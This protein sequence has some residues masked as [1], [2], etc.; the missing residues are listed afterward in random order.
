[1]SA[2]GDVGERAPPAKA[3][4][5]RAYITIE[6]KVTYSVEAVRQLLHQLGLKRMRPKEVPGKAP[7]EEEQR[8]F[9]LQYAVMKGA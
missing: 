6:F 9:V 5:V 3:K 1:V 7:S 8:T 4:Q 2:I